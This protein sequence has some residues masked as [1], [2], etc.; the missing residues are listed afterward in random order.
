MGDQSKPP[1]IPD[2]EA[3]DDSNDEEENGD[4]AGTPTQAAEGASQLMEELSVQEK[5]EENSTA[6]AA[7]VES[8]CLLYTSPSPRDAHRSRMPSSA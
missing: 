8:G 6:G 7:A 5:G 2:D 1:L 4:D 3:D